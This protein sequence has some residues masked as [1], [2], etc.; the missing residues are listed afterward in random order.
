M[1]ENFVEVEN[2]FRDVK[3]FAENL[4]SLHYKFLEV[5]V[6]NSKCSVCNLLLFQPR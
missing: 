1:M 5:S 4:L 3:W 6:T 2:K